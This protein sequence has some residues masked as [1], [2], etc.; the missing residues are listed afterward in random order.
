MTDTTEELS[1]DDEMLALAQAVREHVLWQRDCG[2]YGLPMGERRPVAEVVDLSAHLPARERFEEQNAGSSVP[3]FTPTLP[4]SDEPRTNPAA[5]EK[6]PTL[7]AEKRRA[8]LQVL[9]NEVRSCARCPLA[10]G[11]TNAVPGVG[12]VGAELMIVG[13]GP[14]A[15]EDEQGEPFVGKAGQLL[16]KMLTAIG[17]PRNEVFIANVVKCRPPNNRT[18]EPGEMTSCL[19][20]LH[21]QIELVQ[22]KVILVMGSTALQGVLG[23][24]GIT[25]LRGVWKLYRGKTAVMPTFHPA[26]LFHHEEAKRDVWADLKA[27]AKHLGKEIPAR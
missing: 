5:F 1:P 16:D 25:R 7:S 10:P 11:R 4:A 22:P 24:S 15:D 27:V 8:R 23:L 19:P 2:S 14:G 9:A 18:P 17:I 21:E 26:Y 13:E 6:K 12:P 20:Y 3:A